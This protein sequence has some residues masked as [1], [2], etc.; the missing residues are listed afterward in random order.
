VQLLEVCQVLGGR[1]RPAPLDE[2]PRCRLDAVGRHGRTGGLGDELD[3]A[4]HRHGDGRRK[5]RAE[6]LL[7]QGGRVVV[8]DVVAEACEQGR[9]ALDGDLGLLRRRVAD[10]GADPQAPGVA[11]DLLGEWPLRRGG[12]AGVAGDV[13]GHGVEHTGHVAHR[14]GDDELGGCAVP[15]LTELGRVRHPPPGRLEPDD[16]ARAGGVA[17][18]APAIA[19][20][21]DRD[22]AR[23]DGG[24]GATTR[25]PDNAVE[26]PRVARRPERVGLGGGREAE[27]RRVGL[28]DEHEPRLPQPGAQLA[29]AGRHP[30][31][32]AQD[33][34]ALVL[35]RP[36]DGRAEVLHHGRHA[37]ERPL[38][39]L[40]ARDLRP[41][42][43]EQRDHDGVDLRV[44]ALDGGDGPLQQL[45]GRA[46]PLG[47]EGG[48][49]G[50]VEVGEARGHSRYRRRGLSERTFRRT[51]RLR[52]SRSASTRIVNGHIPSGWQ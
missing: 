40:A 24:G 46:L 49:A 23:R 27:L 19:G 36:G 32:V 11:T 34:G 15:S 29:V 26:A 38:T 25:A 3:V 44:D 31:A 52:S 47:D 6:A 9:A 1:D 45:R 16:P 18:R 14:P 28:A 35:R 2:P 21:G 7:V 22:H 37:P 42:E 43:L 30:V 13:A 8:D 20:V 17:D 10:I 5:V 51:S 12:R 4:G 33:L 39:E 41:G 48:L 50:G